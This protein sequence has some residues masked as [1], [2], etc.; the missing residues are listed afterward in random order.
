MRENDTR[1][2]FSVFSKIKAPSITAF[3]KVPNSKGFQQY[4]VSNR[5]LNTSDKMQNFLPAFV[6]A[7]TVLKDKVLETRSEVRHLDRLI[8]YN[9]KS[10]RQTA[11]LP[12]QE[13][14]YIKLNNKAV[15]TCYTLRSE[16][17]SHGHAAGGSKYDAEPQG[18]EE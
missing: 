8:Y 14:P 9:E 1:F 10:Y 12:P 7:F 4:S 3:A 2:W 6:W 11:K 13:L 17:F 16:I 18:K 15:G 5:R